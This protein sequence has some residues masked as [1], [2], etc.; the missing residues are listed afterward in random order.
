MRGLQD[1]YAELDD[2]ESPSQR[3]VADLLVRGIVLNGLAIVRLTRSSRS[4]I[5]KAMQLSALPFRRLL[6]CDPRPSHRHLVS[7]AG[8]LV[9]AVGAAA[10][11]LA[12]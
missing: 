1:G 11:G 7:E 3:R 12:G 2:L 5:Y 6:T 10:L 4:V 9:F 8:S